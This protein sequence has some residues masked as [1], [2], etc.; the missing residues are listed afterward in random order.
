ME[1]SPRVC[2]VTW[3]REPSGYRLFFNRD[4][5]RSR[6]EAEPPRRHEGRAAD[7]AA[8]AFLAPV[9]G[10]HG[11]TWIAANEHGVTVGLVNGYRRADASAPADVRSRGLLV[12]DLA[13]CRSVRE[14]GGRRS[15]GGP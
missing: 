9:D 10:D 6:L 15:R 1:V 4:E 2:T 11:G 7:G 14:G 8:V 3:L 5:L 12:R 13:G